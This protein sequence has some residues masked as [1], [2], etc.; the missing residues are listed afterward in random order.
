MDILPSDNNILWI[1]TDKWVWLCVRACVGFYWLNEHGHEPYRIWLWY[2]H[3]SIQ[4]LKSLNSSEFKSILLALCCHCLWT[5]RSLFKSCLC[6]HAQMLTHIIHKFML[7]YISL[8]SPQKPSA[9]AWFMCRRY[10]LKCQ[11]PNIT[12]AL[13]R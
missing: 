9:G 10:A 8:I 13:R 2:G 12:M 7:M 1:G 11:F 6:L 4:W 3:R 5:N